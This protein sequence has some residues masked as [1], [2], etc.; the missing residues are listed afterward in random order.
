[1]GE[2][3]KAFVVGF[4]IDHSLS[5]FIHG[6]WL[7]TY[8]IK[9][10]YEAYA[11]LPE[12]FMKF[13]TTLKENGF[14]G[15]NV[16]LPHKEQA[17]QLADYCD[18]AAKAI[19][20]ANSLWFEE[21]RLCASNSDAYGFSRNLDDFAPDWRDTQTALVLGAGGAARAII[22]ALKQQRFKKILLVNRTPS[23]AQKL[24][25]YFGSLINVVDWQ[26]INDY[27][28]KVDLIIN[29]TSIGL[30]NNKAVFPLDFSY[31]QKDVIV[32]DIVY[33]PLKTYFLQ[34]AAMQGLKTVDGLGM[35]LHQ[36]VFGFERWFGIKPTVS[37]ELRRLIIK[38]LEKKG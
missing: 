36:A 16:T 17:L 3:R 30:N 13:I 28:D 11:V 15:G 10:S 7:E 12:N 8:K 33:T 34:A 23:R 35:L 32:H 2:K 20:A 24:A 6:F 9:G 19:G 18:D 14:V 37:P 25:V 38:K 29:T 22:F 31:A 4:P 1:M 27:L 26:Y 5:P 21:G